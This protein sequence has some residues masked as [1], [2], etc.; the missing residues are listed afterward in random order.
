VSR[1]VC[2]AVSDSSDP[3]GPKET[4]PTES[5]YLEVV[6]QQPTTT[7]SI[8]HS[9]SEC[10]IGTDLRTTPQFSMEMHGRSSQIAIPLPTNFHTTIHVHLTF[11]KTNTMLF[12]TTATAGDSGG[13]TPMGSFVYAMPNVS[14]LNSILLISDKSSDLTLEMF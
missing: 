8:N 5:Y 12:L 1:D 6:N 9:V 3:S 7:L 14:L 4:F 11:F 2:R 13:L 10:S